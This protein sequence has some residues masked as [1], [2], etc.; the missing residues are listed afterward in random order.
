MDNLPKQLETVLGSS[1][2]YELKLDIDAASLFVHSTTEPKLTVH[3]T[4]TSPVMRDENS[5]LGASKSG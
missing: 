1:R 5:E 2:R 3:V 4:L